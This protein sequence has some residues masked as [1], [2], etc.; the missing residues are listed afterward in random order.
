MKDEILIKLSADVI[1]FIYSVRRG[2]E[3][4]ESGA[5]VITPC[6]GVPIEKYYGD[7]IATD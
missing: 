6:A 4:M 2:A 3:V 5:V 1:G 7:S